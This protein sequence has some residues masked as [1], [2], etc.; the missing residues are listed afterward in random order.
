MKG[1]KKVSRSNCTYNWFSTNLLARFIRG[2]KLGDKRVGT[3]LITNLP[4][5]VWIKQMRD[6]ETFLIF[7]KNYYIIYM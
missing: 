3:T 7:I 6:E 4:R 1:I 5:G 2:I